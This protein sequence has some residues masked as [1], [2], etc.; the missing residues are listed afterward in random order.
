MATHRFDSTEDAYVA[1]QT[2]EHIKN[3][4]ALVIESEQV[5]GL[6]WTWPVSITEVTGDL[7]TV[8]PT[9]ESLLQVMAD[10]KWTVEHL[11]AAVAIADEH[12][13]PVIEVY[14]QMICDHEG[15]TGTCP[16]CGVERS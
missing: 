15:P 9:W 4:D 7:H 13:W 11:K 8:N 12:G 2:D 10:A 16:K 5:V 14:R 1:C 3:G 6:A